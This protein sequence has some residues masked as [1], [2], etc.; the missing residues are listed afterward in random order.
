MCASA[1]G[2]GDE[3]TGRR[4]GDG[5]DGRRGMELELVEGSVATAAAAALSSAAT[6]AKVKPTHW[7]KIQPI[8]HI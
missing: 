7:L 2:D 3:N 5:D 6:K 8:A 4:E 1:R